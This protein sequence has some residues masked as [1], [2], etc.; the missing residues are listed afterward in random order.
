M[1]HYQNVG[2]RS[3]ATKE[4]YEQKCDTVYQHFYESYMGQG[5]GV[6]AVMR[7]RPYGLVRMT[8]K[9]RCK[10]SSLTPETPFCL[11]TYLWIRLK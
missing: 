4:L 9:N 3:I 5:R 6:Y 1:S 11:C 7:T 8:G 10:R 2:N